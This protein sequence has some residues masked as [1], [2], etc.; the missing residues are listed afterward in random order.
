MNVAREPFAP[1]TEKPSSSD[2]HV[3]AE[4]AILIKVL[5]GAES[6]AARSFGA[7]V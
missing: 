5:L 4:T 7:R 1:G 6:E 2:T 3:E